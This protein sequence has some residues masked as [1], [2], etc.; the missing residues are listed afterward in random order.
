VTTGGRS[1][2]APCRRTLSHASAA[3]QVDAITE[4]RLGRGT[5]ILQKSAKAVDE[6]LLFSLIAEERTVDLQAKSRAERDELVSGFN[7]LISQHH[8]PSTAQAKSR[9]Q[10]KLADPVK[11]LPP[12]GVAASSGEGG[13]EASQRVRA[14]KGLDKRSTALF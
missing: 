12:P 2:V 8:S 4:V 6:S 7:A 10:R 5:A 14:K 13:G 3:A 1:L 9:S 11:A